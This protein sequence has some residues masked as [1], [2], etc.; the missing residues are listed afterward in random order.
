MLTPYQKHSFNITH[1][2]L[3]IIGIHAAVTVPAKG[4]DVVYMQRIFPETD[5]NMCSMC[6]I[7][8]KTSLNALTYVDV[9]GQQLVGHFVLV[10]NVF[11]DECASD[12]TASKETDNSEHGLS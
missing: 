12:S 4:L 1:D 3:P 6:K 11:V 7:T 9:L 2:E 5:R 8:Q 10:E